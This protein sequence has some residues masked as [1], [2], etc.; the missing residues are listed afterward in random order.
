MRSRLDGMS[1]TSHPKGVLMV[2][3]AATD[4]NSAQLEAGARGAFAGLPIKVLA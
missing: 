2:N 4:P 3:G 1:P